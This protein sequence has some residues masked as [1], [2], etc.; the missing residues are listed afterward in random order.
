MAHRRGGEHGRSGEDYEHSLLLLLRTCLGRIAAVCVLCIRNR[1]KLWT[2]CGQARLSFNCDT[3][4]S[5]LVA[6]LTFAWFNRRFMQWMKQNYAIA[7]FFLTF[8]TLAAI[9]LF[10]WFSAIR[11]PTSS[12]GV[13]AAIS[14]FACSLPDF[15]LFRVVQIHSFPGRRVRRF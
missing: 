4:L 10:G 11:L 13:I 6:R 2:S 8:L 5:W 3:R 15:A 7:L 1:S 12:F 9:R 14:F